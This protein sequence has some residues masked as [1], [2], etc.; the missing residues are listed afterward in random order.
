[1]SRNERKTANWDCLRAL[2]TQIGE[3]KFAQL[4]MDHFATRHALG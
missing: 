4:E 2:C 1:M 3:V